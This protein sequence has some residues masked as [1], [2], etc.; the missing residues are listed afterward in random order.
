MS[1]SP[2]IQSIREFISGCSYLSEYKALLVDRLEPGIEAYSI[3]AIPCSPVIKY[4]AN[5]DSVRQFQFYFSSTEAYSQEVLDE[6]ENSAFF[7]HFA[8][9]ME[10]QTRAKTLPELSGDRLATKLEALTH[11][12]VATTDQTTARYVIQCRLTYIQ[13]GV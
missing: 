12:Y 8:A 4:Y 13:R 7:E 10:Q 5:G 2:I 1:D 6:I 11:G 3:E 9:W